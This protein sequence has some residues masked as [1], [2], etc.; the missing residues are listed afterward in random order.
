[1]KCDLCEKIIVNYNETF[2]H[3]IIDKEHSVNICRECADKFAKWQSKIYSILFPT[4][5]MKKI[6]SEK[7]E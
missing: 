4:K 7:K 5:A 2:N 1:M 3:L 6:Y